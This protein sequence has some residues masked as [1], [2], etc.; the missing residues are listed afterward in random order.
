MIEVTAAIV[1]SLFLTSLI[2]GVCA[3]GFHKDLQVVEEKNNWL[4]DRVRDEKAV[5][6]KAQAETRST[7]R[8][9]EDLLAYLKE[10]RE[11]R[12]FEQSSQVCR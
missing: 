12:P 10:S 5:A 11:M 8:R 3:R 9:A 7:H 4:V 2:V 1:W 6:N